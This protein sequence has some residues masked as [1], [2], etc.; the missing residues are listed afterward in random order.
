MIPNSKKASWKSPAYG[1]IWRNKQSAMI[2]R[3]PPQLGPRQLA[4][5]ESARSFTCDKDKVRIMG[6]RGHA[7]E[8]AGH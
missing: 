7:V 4:P 8:L 3:R 2:C 1:G 6:T 5:D